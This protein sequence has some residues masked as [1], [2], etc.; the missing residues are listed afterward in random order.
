[1]M[2]SFPVLKKKFNKNLAAYINGGCLSR[3]DSL[4]SVIFPIIPF[5]KNAMKIINNFNILL[6]SSPK[7]ISTPVEISV[8]QYKGNN[9]YVLEMRRYLLMNLKEDLYGAYVHGSIGTYEEVAYSDFDGLAIIHDEVFRNPKKLSRVAIKLNRARSIMYQFDPLQHH[10]WFVLTKADLDNYPEYYFPSELFR[11]AKSI[12]FNRG[13]SLKIK[14]SVESNPG[15]ELFCKLSNDILNKIK[16]KKYPNNMYELKCFLSNFMLLPTSYINA[17]YK[18]EIFKKF[19]FD[20]AKKDFSPEDWMIIDEVSKIRK[21]WNYN[22]SFLRKLLITK[23]NKM[24][25]C[26]AKK[27][28]PSIPNSIKK[29]LTEDFYQRIENLITNMSVNLDF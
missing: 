25:R 7:N 5:K 17:K 6:A 3:I 23:T 1:M 28:A 21:N 24:S 10:G 29:F 27:N 8:E 9:V 16:N 14:R 18:K 20:V 12:F 4:I 2:E 26:L 11:F 22:I 13:L 15:K 19:S